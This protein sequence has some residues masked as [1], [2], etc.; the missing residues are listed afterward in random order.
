ML[1]ADRRRLDALLAALAE[2][3]RDAFD[4][5]FSLCAPLVQRYARRALP[6]ADAEDAAQTALLKV[7]SRAS[8]YDTE[9]PALP[10]ILGIAS[11]EIRSARK[12][13]LRRREAPLEHEGSTS[14][15]TPEDQAAERQLLEA[16]EDALNGLSLLDRE[17]IVAAI[18]SRER[19]AVSPATFRKRWQRALRRLRAALLEA[20]DG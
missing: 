6:Q 13:V 5:L 12:R 20:G 19:P 2:G 10:W 16:A 17:A 18:G 14:G 9:R 15:P 1:A 4:P 11:N 8:D 7:F 3:D